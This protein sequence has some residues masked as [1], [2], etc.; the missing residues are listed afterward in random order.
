MTVTQD[1][2]VHDADIRRRVIRRHRDAVVALQALGFEGPVVYDE[3]SFPLSYLLL[4][5]LTKLMHAKG[6]VVRSTRFLCLTTAYPLLGHRETPTFALVSALGVKFLTGFTDGT[7][8]LTTN[9]VRTEHLDA[10]AQYYKYVG[11]E[12]VEALWVFHQ[13]KLEG[14]LKDGKEIQAGRTFADYVWLS[15]IETM[16][17]SPVLL[18]KFLSL[19]L[20]RVLIVLFLF[21]VVTLCTRLWLLPWLEVILKTFIGKG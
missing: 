21:V 5:P 11:P 1:E 15:R 14:L 3:R 9:T 6:A 10:A 4:W 20:A 12:S 18:S 13:N 2:L 7:L 8:L 19:P 17:E 16:V